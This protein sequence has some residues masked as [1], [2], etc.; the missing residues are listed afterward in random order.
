MVDQVKLVAIVVEEGAL[1]EDEVGHQLAD[2]AHLDGI[3]L[4]LVFHFGLG[5]LGGQLFLEG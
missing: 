5:E 3:A 2:P 4:G 1:V